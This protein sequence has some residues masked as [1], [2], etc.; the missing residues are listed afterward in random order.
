MGICFQQHQKPVRV[1][2]KQP[3]KK[4]EQQ[5]TGF[6]ENNPPNQQDETVFNDMQEW[7]G[8]QLNN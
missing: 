6:K 4:L 5:A 2:V 7:E 3:K 8:K 1:E